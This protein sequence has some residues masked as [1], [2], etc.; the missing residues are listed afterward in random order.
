M[1]AS[2]GFDQPVAPRLRN[3][4]RSDT[5]PSGLMRKPTSIH[6]SSTLIPIRVLVSDRVPYGDLTANG[7]NAREETF[8]RDPNPPDSLLEPNASF[9]FSIAGRLSSLAA[10]RTNSHGG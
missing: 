8:T 9:R 4:C 10:P 1:D 7:S 2:R 3:T 5:L 6:M